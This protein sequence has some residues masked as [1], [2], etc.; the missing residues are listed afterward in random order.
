[1]AVDKRKIE[2]AKKKLQEKARGEVTYPPEFDTTK[3]GAVISGVVRR[4][5]VIPTPS[6]RQSTGRLLEIETENGSFTI[7]E[8]TVLTSELDRQGVGVGDTIAI[9]CLGKVPKKNY[10]GFVVTKV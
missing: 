8:K 4:R 3:K 9:E 5:E 7:W 10:Y 6:G 2:E 1:M